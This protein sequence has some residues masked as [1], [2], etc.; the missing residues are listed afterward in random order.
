MNKTKSFP[1]GSHLVKDMGCP[2]GGKC[3]VMQT[4]QPFGGVTVG[5][6]H[7]VK[8]GLSDLDSC[9]SLNFS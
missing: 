7:Q 2:R 5:K 8:V 4:G 6:E 3:L 1:E 9:D